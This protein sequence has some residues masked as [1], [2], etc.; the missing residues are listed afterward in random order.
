MVKTNDEFLSYLDKSVEEMENKMRELDQQIKNG[1]RELNSSWDVIVQ[2]YNRTKIRRQAE[3]NSNK[4]LTNQ[5]VN[6]AILKLA[7]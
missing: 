2:A 5:E 7:V 3:I 6:N 4:L 1:Y